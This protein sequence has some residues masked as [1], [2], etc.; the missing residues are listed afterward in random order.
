M[1]PQC[2]VLLFGKRKC[3][4]D[5]FASELAKNFTKVSILHLSNPIKRDFAQLHG[6]NFEELLTS[7][8]YKDIYRKEMIAFGEAQR[9]LDSFVFCQGVTKDV[10]SD[11]WIVVDNRRP[12]DLEYFTL[13]YPDKCMTVKITANE[14]TRQ[15]R[16]WTWT[17]GVDNVTSE[18]GLDHWVPDLV[19]DNS[20][21]SSEVFNQSL[22]FVKT[23]CERLSKQ[24]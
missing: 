6:L 9:N 5:Y 21:G 20:E 15:G 16:G 7:S 18:C 4:K 8:A 24:S 12:T 17:E 3:G 14:S 2:I 1:E 23:F 10:T 22:G 19:V 13:T 11:V